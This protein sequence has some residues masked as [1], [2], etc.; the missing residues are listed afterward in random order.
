MNMKNTWKLIIAL[1]LIACMAAA[2]FA[3]DD[4]IKQDGPIYVSTGDGTEDE[5]I[6]FGD[7]TGDGTTEGNTTESNTTE[8]NTVGG[9]TTE[10]PTQ[11]G[12]GNL[13][14]GGANTEG[15]YGEIIRP[16]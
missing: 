1:A 13:G 4:E 5:G 12:N 10:A 2:M 16:R 6:D 7:L 14:V 8:N 11:T 15:G 3:C 9:N